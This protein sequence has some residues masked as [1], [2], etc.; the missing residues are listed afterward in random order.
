MKT[1]F[2]ISLFV[3]TVVSVSDK[4]PFYNLDDAPK[5]F[6]KF[7]VDFNKTYRNEE[8]YQE[9]FEAFKKSLVLINEVNKVTKEG[10]IPWVSDLTI[11]S[12]FTDK[13]KQTLLNSGKNN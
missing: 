4:I 3:I 11:F 10:L 7:M 6:D 13:E 9:H 2:L 8:D 1:V 12:D 5:I